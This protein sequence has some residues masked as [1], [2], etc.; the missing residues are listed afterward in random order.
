[1]NKTLRLLAYGAIAFA[2]VG[3]GASGGVNAP[4]PNQ[5][6]NLSANK[7]EFAVGT[8]NLFGTPNGALNIAASYRQPNGKS[9]TLL[10]SPTITLPAP[11]GLAPATAL[12]SCTAL[13]AAPIVSYDSSSTVLAGPAPGET[14]TMTSTSQAYG[15]TAVTTFG[16]SGGVFGLGIEPFNATG[17][18]QCTPPAFFSANGTPFQ[19]APYPVPLYDTVASDPNAFIPWGGP[20][21]FTLVNSGGDSVVGNSTDYPAGTAGISE[22]LDVFRGVKA[23]AGGTYTLSITVPVS[24]GSPTT[25]TASFTMPAA[26]TNLGNATAPAFAPNGKGGGT[27]AFVMPAGATQ[28]YLQITDFGPDNAVAGCNGA[29]GAGGPNPATGQ[30]PPPVYYTIETTASGTLTLPDAIGP[31]GTPSVCTAAQNTAANGGTATD[32]DEIAIQ[33]VGFDYDAFDATYNNS[34][35]PSLTNQTPQL[36]GAN[37]TADMTISPAVCQQGAGGC[38]VPLPLLKERALHAAGFVRK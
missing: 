36:F 7:I 19:V 14:T 33:V 38:A 15:S 27:F 9:G 35:P 34:N 24:V 37:G 30:P 28:A 12:T 10:N 20:P 2:L 16:Q 6:A 29:G 26:L 32:A 1:M 17:Q 8:V 18:G 4:A 21:A 22:G 3:C 11:M 5:V 31:G 13:A 25:Q 23:V